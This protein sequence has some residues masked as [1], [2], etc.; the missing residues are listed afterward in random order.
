MEENLSE[1]DNPGPDV[2][3]RD[4]LDRASKRKALCNI[5]AATYDSN[6]ENSDDEFT[7]TK[8]TKFQQIRKT[9][10]SKKN[11]ESQKN[12]AS[13]VSPVEMVEVD[14]TK[15]LSDSELFDN[16][17]MLNLHKC[18]NTNPSINAESNYEQLQYPRRVVPPNPAKKNFKGPRAKKKNIIQSKNS[19]VKKDLF[20]ND[21]EIN[22]TLHELNEEID[23]SDCVDITDEKNISPVATHLQSKIQIACSYLE[24][25][26]VAEEQKLRAEEEARKQR[27][28]EKQMKKDELRCKR[29][30]EQENEN[31]RKIEREQNSNKAHNYN[32]KSLKKVTVS[33]FKKEPKIQELSEINIDC[34]LVS[35]S[36]HWKLCYNVLLYL[37]IFLLHC[38]V[39]TTIATN[40]PNYEASALFA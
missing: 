19:F 15:D 4:K 27:E 2:S 39:T 29:L 18:L 13:F 28:E 8:K 20:L 34:R 31:R 1:E 21:E 22:K 25:V 7:N 16:S 26:H 32:T 40:V 11:Q 24:N 35:T 23:D 12:K 37:F 5:G 36:S 33:N 38:R 9:E 3:S 6:D 30:Q 17:N 10:E 14:D